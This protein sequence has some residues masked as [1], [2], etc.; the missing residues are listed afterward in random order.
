MSMLTSPLRW[1]VISMPPQTRSSPAAE[2][3]ELLVH[4]ARLWRSLG[5]HDSEGK[6]HIDGVTGPDEYSAIADDN[7][8]TNL[9][10]RHNLAS[11][12][13]MAE[14]YPERARELG[15]DPEES[16]GWRDA[17]DSMHVPYDEVLSVHP[18]AASFT[19]HQVWDFAGT[20]R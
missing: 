17:A 7:V 3:T 20:P 11:A 9:M 12:A 2:G 13:A 8:Y 19:R 16:A 14:K 4:T 6:F 1:S 18:Q 15:V 10:A 5:H